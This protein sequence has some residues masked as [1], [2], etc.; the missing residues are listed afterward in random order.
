MASKPLPALLIYALN[1]LLEQLAKVHIQSIGNSQQGIHCWIV[2][3]VFKAAYCRLIQ[4]RQI[5]HFVFGKLKALPFVSHKA[6]K[7]SADGIAA[8]SFCHS[9]SLQQILLDD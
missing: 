4:T 2:V 8:F 1:R 6:N 7:F 3:V 9:D 5:R